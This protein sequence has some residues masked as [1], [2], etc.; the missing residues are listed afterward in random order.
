MDEKK[1]LIIIINKTKIDNILIE[2]GSNIIKLR[3][4]NNLSQKK[5]SRIIRID[6]SFL[7]KVENGKTNLSFGYLLGIQFPIF[8]SLCND[9]AC[10]KSSTSQ[11]ANEYCENNA[12]EALTG[13]LSITIN[14]APGLK[15]TG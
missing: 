14:F 1:Y 2:L 8:L 6:K 15:V 9:H 7:C 3:L 11:P 12:Y 13:S 10:K 4:K 5:L